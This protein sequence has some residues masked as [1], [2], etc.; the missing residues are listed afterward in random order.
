MAL[1]GAAQYY[2]LPKKMHFQQFYARG[3]KLF[4]VVA[5]WREI[6]KFF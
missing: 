3:G 1:K 5:V 4:S 6:A 2:S